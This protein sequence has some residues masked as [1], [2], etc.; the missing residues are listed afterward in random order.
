MEKIK[1]IL[2]DSEESG[3]L[4]ALGM[5]LC[6]AFFALAE[7]ALFGC[8]MIALVWFGFNSIKGRPRRWSVIF[9]A[10]AIWAQLLLWTIL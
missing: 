8:V 6:L 10:G 1:E 5:T 2:K 9:L 7:I 4:F 3:W